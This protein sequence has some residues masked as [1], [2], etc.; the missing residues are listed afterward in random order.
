MDE[1]VNVLMKTAGCNRADAQ[2]ALKDADNDLGRALELLDA[3]QK[4]VLVFHVMFEPKAGGEG[5][6]FLSA[7]FD[8]S[9]DNAIYTDLVYPL[10]GQNAGLL[11]IKM[12]PTVFAK[13]LESAKGK[14]SDRHRGASSSNAALIRAKLGPTIIR[15]AVDA[16]NKAQIDNINR[17]FADLINTVFSAD[18]NVQYFARSQSLGSVVS[19]LKPTGGASEQPEDIASK[20]FGKK[21]GPSS[22]APSPDDI[23]GTSPQEPIP[24]IVLICEAEIS[25]FAGKPAREIVEGDE[26]IVKIKDARES[27]RYFAELIGGAV[28]DELIPLVVPVIKTVK[29]ADTFMESYVEFGPGIYGQFF[30]PPDVKIK[31]KTEGIEIYNPFQDEESLFADERFGKQIIRGLIILIALVG[32]LIATLL[33]IGLVIK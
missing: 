29:V 9:K 10:G 17:I 24:Q 25:P 7:V 11:D 31:M 19:L 3:A 13:T 4:E 26:V 2:N 20:L 22:S 21:D 8:I 18:F 14:L 32:V 33:F 12:P 30:T 6:G 15:K 5:K 23:H 1:N 27:A 28:G 16:H